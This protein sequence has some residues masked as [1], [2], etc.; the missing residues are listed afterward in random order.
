MPRRRRSTC[1]VEEALEA[2]KEAKSHVSDVRDSVLD[3]IEAATEYD[4]SSSPETAPEVSHDEDAD[5]ASEGWDAV[6]DFE[7]GDPFEE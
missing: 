1:D 7:W 5:S 3:D 4:V 6:D 2:L